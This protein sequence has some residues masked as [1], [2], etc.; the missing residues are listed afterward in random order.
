MIL[1]GF[2][3]TNVAFTFAW[4]D[5]CLPYKIWG[6]SQVSVTVNVKYRISLRILWIPLNHRNQNSWNGPISSLINVFSYSGPN[7]AVKCRRVHLT[8]TILSLLSFS[9]FAFFKYFFFILFLLFFFFLQNDVEAPAYLRTPGY[10]PVCN[11]FHFCLAKNP[12]KC[13]WHWE[14]DRRYNFFFSPRHINV[15]SHITEILLHVT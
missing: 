8:L 3:S 4:I 6:K 10:A 13:L 1:H 12:T 11:A 15:P 14:P 5:L 2:L 9:L 7:I